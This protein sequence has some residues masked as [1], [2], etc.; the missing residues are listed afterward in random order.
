MNVNIPESVSKVLTG[1][2]IT[3]E[4]T[5][6]DEGNCDENGCAIG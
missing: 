2:L 6:G 3:H 5:L 1:Y 4:E